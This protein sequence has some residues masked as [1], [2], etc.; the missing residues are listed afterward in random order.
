MGWLPIYFWVHEGNSGRGATAVL[1]SEKDFCTDK[2]QC[3]LP[4]SLSTV[5][6]PPHLSQKAESQ[7][8]SQ[9]SLE[10]SLP[11]SCLGSSLF[12]VD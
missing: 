9:C 8:A 6:L 4:A 11:S 2:Y 3:K 12:S 1:A 7:L 10:L 5:N